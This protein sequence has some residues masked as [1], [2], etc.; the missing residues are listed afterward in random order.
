MKPDIFLCLRSG[1]RVRTQSKQNKVQEAQLETLAWH[2]TTMSEFLYM[3]V[4]TEN[5]LVMPAAA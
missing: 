4:I 3:S 1:M 5:R 2:R